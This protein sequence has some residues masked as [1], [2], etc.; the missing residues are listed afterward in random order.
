[1]RKATQY[2]RTFSAGLAVFLF[3][4]CGTTAT[5]ESHPLLANASDSDAARIYFIR[6]DPGFDGVVG[7]A[8]KIS[9]AGEELLSLAK[10]EYTL[11]Y[12]KNYSG[13]VTVE[14]TQVENRMGMNTQVTV[15]ETR[16]FTFGAFRTYYIT[17]E[18]SPR[19]YVPHSISEE[20]ARTL[21]SELKPIGN[22]IASPL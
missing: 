22:A 13:D 19:G 10:G 2:A 7:N 3:F 20:A 21:S 5:R 6:P 15:E 8:F 17:F 14:S 4:G 12:L 1:M 16:L 11:V 18:E 9:M